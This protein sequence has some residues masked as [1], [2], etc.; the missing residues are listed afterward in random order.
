MNG[1]HFDLFEF[2]RYMLA[3]LVTVYS[4]VRLTL[5]I[6]RWQGAAGRARGGSEIVYR[7]LVVLLLR[8]RF[9]RFAYELA[10]IGGLLLILAVLI[11]MHWR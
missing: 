2:Y 4:V 10:V 8:A 1:P 9:R 5:F 6:W 3:V 7:Y 11:I